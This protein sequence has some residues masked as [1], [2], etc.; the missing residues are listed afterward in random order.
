M[1]DLVLPGFNDLI[2]IEAFG[3]VAGDGHA[4]MMGFV[5]DDFHLFQFH[6]AINLHLLETG[7][8][9]F[10]GPHFGLFGRVHARHAE[11]QRPAAVHDSRE[12]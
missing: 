11:G 2:G 6:R 10:V 7:V 1:I 9:I 12:Q 3:D 5:G 8:V 4:E